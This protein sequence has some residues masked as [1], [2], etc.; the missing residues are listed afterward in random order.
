MFTLIKNIQKNVDKKL[1]TFFENKTRFLIDEFFPASSPADLSDISGATYLMSVHCSAIIMKNKMIKIMKKLNPNKTFELN[2]ITNWFLKVCEN[3]LINV[4]TSF[5]QTCVDQ[6]YHFKTYQKN[7]TIILRKSDKNNYDVVK[8]W[9][10]IILLN[11]MNKI[12]ESIIKK[13]LLYLMKHH[14]WLFIT[15]MKT[16]LN[17]STK[18]ILKFLIEQMHTM[19]KIKTNKIATLLNMN[20]TKVFSIINYM[21]LIYNLWKKK[22]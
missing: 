13:K 22:Y 6:K 1:T 10:S 17:R 9:H 8:T 2:N 3:D 12:L 5:F 15:Q 11:M 21:K 16:W 14:D 18:I 19:W 7:N 20:V 4:L